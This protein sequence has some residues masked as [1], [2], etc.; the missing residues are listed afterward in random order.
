MP[1]YDWHENTIDGVAVSATLP[2]ARIFYRT[3][4]QWLEDVISIDTCV[5]QVRVLLRNAEGGRVY[6][7]AGMAVIRVL[8][9]DFLLIWEGEP[10]EVPAKLVAEDPVVCMIG[11]QIACF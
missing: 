2:P 5:K 8:T 3:T 1:L 4:G 7:K 6:D 10:P 11:R 9:G